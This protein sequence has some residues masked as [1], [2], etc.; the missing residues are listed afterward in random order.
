M[1]CRKNTGTASSDCSSG[2][3]WTPSAASRSKRAAGALYRGLRRL[4]Q[5]PVD[6]T[7]ATAARREDLTTAQ[8]DLAAVGAIRPVD[9][10]PGAARTSARHYLA[11]RLYSEGR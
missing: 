6:R 3:V 1:R 11:L 2:T 8:R 5:R 10:G 4:N 7:G 9:P